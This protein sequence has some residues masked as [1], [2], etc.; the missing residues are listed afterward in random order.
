MGNSIIDRDEQQQIDFGNSLENFQ[1]EMH[2]CCQ[3]LRSHIEDAADNVQAENARA[4]L[5][6][7]LELIQQIESE[8]PGTAEFGARQKKLG[9]HI[10]EASNFRFSRH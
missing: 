6:Y 2:N 8:L 7:L 3:S 9:K 5:E 10:E 1:E 4:A